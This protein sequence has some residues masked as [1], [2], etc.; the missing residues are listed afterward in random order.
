MNTRQFS[1]G[2][3]R[4]PARDV[5]GAPDQMRVEF[6]DVAFSIAEHNDDTNNEPS[7]AGTYQIICQTLGLANFAAN[8]MNGFRHRAQQY[9]VEAPWPRFYDVVLRLIQAFGNNRFNQYRTGV[10]ALFAA[11]GTAWDLTDNRRL[12]RVLPAAIAVEVTSAI[13]E[14]RAPGYQAALQLFKNAK[15]AF[16]A[17]PR[18]S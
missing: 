14:L 17:R 10:N 12:E 6:V 11:Y 5:E 2:V 4:P 16:D 18:G 13:D 3:N 8:P 9:L 7:S 1:G 15:E